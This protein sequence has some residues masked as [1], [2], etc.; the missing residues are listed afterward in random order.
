MVWHKMPLYLPLKVV[1]Q[2]FL[3][4]DALFGH[5]K[6]EKKFFNELFDFF[7]SFLL[8]NTER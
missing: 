6:G 1:F 5:L 2:L 4:K 7:S 3:D 8:A